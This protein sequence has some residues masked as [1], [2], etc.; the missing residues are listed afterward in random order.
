M[1]INK[2]FA[3]PTDKERYPCLYDWKIQGIMT[4]RA[5]HEISANSVG[6]INDLGLVIPE[7]IRVPEYGWYRKYNKKKIKQFKSYQE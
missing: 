6:E 3:P 2:W 5:L 4:V 1:K 7:G